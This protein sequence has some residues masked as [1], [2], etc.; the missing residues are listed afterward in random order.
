MDYIHVKCDSQQYVACT[1]Y[2]A[3][4]AD[5]V[6]II[7]PATGVLQSFYRPMASFFM[8]N[9]ISV[10][11]FD[12]SGIGKSLNGSIKNETCR[13]AD[14]GCSNLEA[15]IRYTR[16]NLPHHKIILLGHSIGGQLI[17]LAPS[18]VFVDKIILIAAQSGYWKFWKGINRIR[19]WLNWYL[20][21]PVFTK[22]YGYLPAKM[23]SRMEHLPGRV[24]KEWADWCRNSNYLFGHITVDN[25]HFSKIKCK[26]TSISISDD[27]FAPE[28][29]VEWLT[30]KY[31]NAERKRLHFIPENFGVSKIGHFSLFTE[32][33]GN[34]IWNILF[35]EVIN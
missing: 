19:M 5:K 7:V 20:L 35:T 17:G 15:V 8:R 2:I 18:S 26:L 16:V 12:Y 30:A 13:I 4:D 27:F 6:V 25:L 21:V 22:V 29:S 32:K 23:I 10:I 31:V 9:A 1:K 34:S 33:F 11:T 28:Q 14:W 3:A 24:A